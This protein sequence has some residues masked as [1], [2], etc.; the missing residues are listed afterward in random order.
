LAGYFTN[1]SDAQ[2]AVQDLIGAGFSESDI[3]FAPYNDA[4]AGQYAGTG[5]YLESSTYL[6]QSDADYANNTG[7]ALVTVTGSRAAE[8]RAILEQDGADIS[9]RVNPGLANEGVQRIQLR[10]ERLSARKQTVQAGEVQVHK[11]VITETRTVDVPVSHEEVVIERRPV[12]DR[13]VAD[14]PIGQDETIRVPLNREEVTL[15]KQAYVREEVEVGK[16]S[17]TETEHLSGTVRREEARVENT[18]DV[19]IEDGDHRAEML[20]DA[21]DPSTRPTA[22]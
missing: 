13:T 2:R 11:D 19:H 8:A 6:N 20:D 7:G 4:A 21:A 3:D 1:R 14:T 10:E 18:G 5:Q 17:V 12:T 9:D 15:E 22:R 16:R